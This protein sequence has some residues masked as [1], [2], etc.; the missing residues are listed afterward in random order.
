MESNKKVALR[1]AVVPKDGA[2]G[3]FDDSLLMSFKDYLG[4]SDFITLMVLLRWRAPIE[5]RLDIHKI[6][7]HVQWN[8][9]A[10]FLIDPKYCDDNHTIWNVVEREPRC[11]AYVNDRFRDDR[12]VL[13][14]AL[15]SDNDCRMLHF[16]SERVKSDKNTYFKLADFPLHWFNDDQIGKVLQKVQPSLC[17]DKEFILTMMEILDSVYLF[18]FASERLRNDKH[19]VLFC[20]RKDYRNYEYMGS[21]CRDDRDIMMFLASH[22]NVLMECGNKLK[23]DREFMYMILCM[24]PQCFWTLNAELRSDRSFIIDLLK[25]HRGSTMLSY[26]A[27]HMTDN[28]KDDVS[29]ACEMFKI[30][31]YDRKEVIQYFTS[32]VRNNRSIRKLLKN[33]ET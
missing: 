9:L 7:R 17:D 15:Y 10:Y 5:W 6:C 29:F 4:H 21:R 2:F 25:F 19:L 33:I 24:D 28:L 26:V 23:N 20:M 27:K 14:K 8:P 30:G 1:Q 11:F 12:V 13:F 16:A 22:I 3:V 32:K 31:H 18:R